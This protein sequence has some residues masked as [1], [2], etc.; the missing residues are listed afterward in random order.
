MT[1]WEWTAFSRLLITCSKM[2]ALTSN[3]H[4]GVT[5]C[6]HSQSCCC[7]FYWLIIIITVTYIYLSKIMNALLKEVMVWSFSPPSLTHYSFFGNTVLVFVCVDFKLKQL[8][9]TFIDRGKEVLYYWHAQLKNW[10]YCSLD[11]IS[12]F[13]LAACPFGY[14][15]FILHISLYRIF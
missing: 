3:V 1:G 12:F 8:L 7:A 10:L 2:T 11:P 15:V 9:T 5:F 6:I 13:C 4:M 14:M